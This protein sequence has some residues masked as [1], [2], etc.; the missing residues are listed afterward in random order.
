MMMRRQEFI[1]G[2]G[3]ATAWSLAARA[4]QSERDR[5]LKGAK[6]ADLPIL[7]PIKIEMVINLEAAKA[8]DLDVPL[9]VLAL[10]DEV[11]E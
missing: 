11:I 7:Q 3:S 2:L 4:Q 8:L 10:A 1:G 5:I 9:A 6:P